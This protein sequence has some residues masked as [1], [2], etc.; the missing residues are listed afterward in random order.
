MSSITEENYLKA[1]YMLSSKAKGLSVSELAAELKL[2]APTVTGMLKKLASKKLI[3]YEKYRSFTLTTKGEAMALQIIRKHRLWELFLV[4]KL[5]FRW[6]EVHEMA[7]QLEHI[8][9][10][11][12]IERIDQVLGFPK[13][14]PHGDPIPD[15][16]GMLPASRSISLSKAKVGATYKIT[17]VT[18]HSSSFLNYLESLQIG[19]AKKIKIAGIVEYDGSVIIQRSGQPDKT[20]IGYIAA[21]HLQVEKI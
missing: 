18:D 8:Q 7:E 14:D 1:L 21:L 10:L 4:K 19:L 13:F 9:S 2:S 3:H 6:D 12:L 20:T 17:G 15:A 5:G 16:K 11:T